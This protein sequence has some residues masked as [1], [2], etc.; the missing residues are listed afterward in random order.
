MEKMMK[1][2][3]TLLLCVLCLQITY[4][5]YDDGLISAGEYEG[6][7]DWLDGQLI[8]DGGGAVIIEVW[9]SACLEVRSTS[10]P[11]GLGKGGIMDIALTNTSRLDYYGGLT[12]EIA[13]YK[14][15]TAN[16]YD[17]RIDYIT[18]YQ[19]ATTQHINITCQTGWEW[20]WEGQNIVGI[21]GLWRNDTGF[22][23][24]F[25]DKQNLGFDPV[26]KNINIIPE[27]AT[28]TLLGIG[29][30]LLRRKK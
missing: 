23:I 24:H 26:W 22:T 1:R 15:A 25:I 8:V 17:G 20:I 13:L 18:S 14:N 11:L 12:E 16:L 2:I 6:G 7:V 3:I 10:T 9:N 4:A 5:G 27:P 19:Y 21:T 30:L 28:L 29:G